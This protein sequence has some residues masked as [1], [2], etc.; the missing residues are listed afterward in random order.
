MANARDLTL[1]DPWQVRMED[2]P[3]DGSARDRL[4]YLLNYA[5]LAPSILNSQPWRFRLTDDALFVLAERTRLL[6]VT[7]GKGRELTISCGAA[8][9][10]LRIAARGL[11]QQAVVD[12][13]PLPEDQHTL[14]KVVLSPAAEPSIEEREQF[15]AITR[16]R[17]NR[18]DFEHR[19]LP[20]RLTD[21]LAAAAHEGAR[22]VVSRDPDVARRVGKLVADGR[23]R[24]FSDSAHRE[25]LAAWI[26][27]R[28]RE[29]HAASDEAEWRTDSSLSTRPGQ[30]WKNSPR[31]DLEV[32]MATQVAR[33]FGSPSR[34]D[35]F[36]TPDADA[37]PVLALL[38]TP[39]DTI[40]DWLIAGQTLQAVLLR[41]AAADVSAS[42]F[43]PPIEVGELRQQVAEAFGAKGVP[44][45]LLQLGYARAG[46]P[47]ARRPVGEV[48]D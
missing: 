37:G 11:G 5:V 3:R 20:Q 6:P 38:T 39:R 35:Q 48:M 32:P 15:E 40:R 27:E 42:Y 21:S 34:E 47:V 7:D 30:S 31:P 12:L 14:A 22:L 45:V 23:R 16:R 24:Q 8:L 36:V 2:F 26:K 1:T 44:Q 43:S 25:E 9:A 46:Q 41:A 10:N 18:S 13:L 4:L 29:G 19:S 33:M 17:T 28:W